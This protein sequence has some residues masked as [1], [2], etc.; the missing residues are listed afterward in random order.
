MTQEIENSQDVI[1]SRD[2]I[3]RIE[4]LQAEKLDL[5]ETLDDAVKSFAEVEEKEEAAEA[6]TEWLE[7]YGDELK[8]L[9]DLADE[10]G[11]S[12]DWPHGE[13]LIRESYFTEYCEELC[14]DIGD[15]PNE[16]PWYIANHIDWEGVA[17]EIQQDYT[18]VDFDGVTYFIRA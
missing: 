2:V 4:E 11:S 17:R 9:E 16:L 10:A 18:Q 8:T 7:D 15:I 1:D 14:K 5:E 12:P 13:A 6:L 3:Q